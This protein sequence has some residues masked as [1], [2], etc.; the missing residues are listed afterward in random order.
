MDL[1]T[2]DDNK[3]S[4]EIT[5]PHQFPLHPCE[6][7]TPAAKQNSIKWENMIRNYK[8]TTHLHLQSNPA[9]HHGGLG[10]DRYRPPSQVGKHD[11]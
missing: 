3:D 2:N 9:C 10:V 7:R 5:L 8:L 6:R 11:P 1:W 4:Y